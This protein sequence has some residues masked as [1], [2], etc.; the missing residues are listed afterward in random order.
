MDRS[1]IKVYEAGGQKLIQ[2]F[3]G[4]SR[5]ELLAI[6]IPGTWSLQQIA[7]HMMESDL[8]GTDRMKR[9]AAMDNPLLIGYDESAFARLPGV[10][11]LDA[12]AACRLFEQNRHMTATILRALPDAAFERWGIHNE[13]GKVTLAEMVDKYIRHV[14]DHLVHVYKKRA[15]LGKH[16][17]Q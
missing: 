8:I 3:A 2:A 4:L 1:R 6:P 14:D 11:T 9:I 15:L 7:I 17:T 10:D 13:I 12:T 16:E 5:N